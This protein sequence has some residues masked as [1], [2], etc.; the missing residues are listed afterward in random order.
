MLRVKR[1]SAVCVAFLAFGGLLAGCGKSS[2]STTAAVP[3]HAA[4]TAARPRPP[5]TVPAGIDGLH[6]KAQA[7]AFVRAVNLRA[8]DLPGFTA[9]KKEHGHE[10]ASEKRLE[11]ETLRCAGAQANTSDELAE[12]RSMEFKLEHGLLDLSVSSAVSVART[13]AA[14]AD[15]IA[16]FRS[17]HV[18]ACLSHYLDLL[19]KGKQYKRST[20]GPV[21]IASGTPPAPGTTGGFGWRITVT[22]TAHGVKIP[23]YFDILGFVDGQAAVTLSSTGFVAPFPASIQQ[24]LYLLLLNRAKAHGA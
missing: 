24:Q 2:R 7:I 13:S 15:E 17:R 12:A 9:S 14:A 16:E 20:V 6:T 5:K 18:Q 3:V 1:Q 21:S 19:F 22:V 4:T 8:T 23:L 10:D 11:R